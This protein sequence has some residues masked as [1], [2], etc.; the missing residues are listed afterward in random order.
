MALPKFNDIPQYELTIPSTKNKV[1]YRPFLVKE[2]KV[3]LIALESQDEKQVLNAI[4]NTIESCILDPIDVKKLSTF[5]VEY[6]FIQIRTKSAGETS[7]IGL[8]CSNADC[9]HTNKVSVK[10]EDIK[11]DLPNEIKSIKINDQYT[12][13]L[14]YPNYQELLNE[15]DLNDK[16]QVN[17]LYGLLTSCLGSLNTDE[18]RISFLDE[19]KEEIEGFLNQL[20]TDQFAEVMSFANNLPK[21]KHDVSYKCEEC[22]NENIRTLEGLADFFQSPFLMTA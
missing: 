12:L 8:A 10:L 15:V 21:L 1:S 2:Q 13:V 11:I 17:Q 4:M 19:T 16:S 9:D 18:E 3:L 5:D 14:K 20:T 7:D 22:G 6:I